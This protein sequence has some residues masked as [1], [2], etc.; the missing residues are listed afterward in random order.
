[1]TETNQNQEVK[2][3]TLAGSKYEIEKRIEE[4]SIAVNAAIDEALEAKMTFIRAKLAMRTARAKQLLAEG[5]L[6]IARND[7]I[8]WENE[9]RRAGRGTRPQNPFAAILGLG[10]AA[11]G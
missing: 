5:E 8:K 4:K 9:E 2:S 1:M 7:A 10:G 3:T 11:E 6:T